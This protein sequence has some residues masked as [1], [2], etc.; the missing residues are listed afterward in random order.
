MHRLTSPS[1]HRRLLLVVVAAVA[2]LVS[3]CGLRTITPPGDAPLRYRDAVFSEVTTTGGITY[4]RATKQD[5]ETIDLALDLYR[6]TG[7]TV[8]GR[9]AVVWVHG[10]SFAFGNRTSPEIVD[11]ATTLAKKGYVTASISYR[12][13]ERGCT[14]VSDECITAIVDAKHDAQA[15]VRFLRAHAGDY[16]I[17][18]GRIAVGGTSAGAITALNVAYG[19]DD[20]GT[21]GTPGESSTV[22]AALSLSGASITTTPSAGEP[23]ALLFHGTADNLVPYQWA[24]R[25]VRQAREAGLIAELTTWEGD[26]HVPYSQHR[27]QILDQ[28]TNFLWFTMDLAHAAN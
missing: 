27:Q 8:T 16:G 1:A 25:T 17:D 5:G 2:L 28:T 9:P 14:S 3:G 13:S 12:L 26:G 6:P 11:E 10:G 7:D 18:P 4:G 21:S 19:S 23:A 20:V 15:A 24:E 22:R